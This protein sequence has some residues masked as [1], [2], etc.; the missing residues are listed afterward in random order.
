MTPLEEKLAELGNP[1]NYE[2]LIHKHFH[3]LAIGIMVGNERTIFEYPIDVS[4]EPCNTIDQGEHLFKV[5]HISRDMEDLL[6]SLIGQEVTIYNTETKDSIYIS[7]NDAVLRLRFV[8]DYMEDYMPID[9]IAVDELPENIEEIDQG[10]LD[11][12][13]TLYKVYETTLPA[14]DAQDN[15]ATLITTRST[16]EIGL[17]LRV[18]GTLLLFCKPGQDMAEQGIIEV[19]LNNNQIIELT[20]Q[21]NIRRSRDL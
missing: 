7:Y 1:E 14:R 21:H 13:T 19:G 9:V 10:L 20:V 18:N 15:P 17:T 16:A 12:I 8:L 5:V 3:H 11:Q 4:E 6:G 2:L